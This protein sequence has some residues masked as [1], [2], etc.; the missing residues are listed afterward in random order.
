M[1]QRR[2]EIRSRKYL[3]GSRGQPCTLQITGVCTGDVE[4]T[5]AAH[6]R[7]ETFGKSQKAD[8]ISIADA[9]YACHRVFDGH[10]HTPL[11]S[12][13]WLFYALRGLQ[14][15]FRNRVER[16]LVIVPLDA[17]RLSSERPVPARKPAA[18]RVRIPSNPDRK[19]QSQNNLRKS[20]RL[21]TP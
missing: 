6:I 3:N 9:C 4:T 13:E 10:G 7:D 19:I 14:R 18:Q 5:V 16:G 11:T 2:T 20:E 8:D 12:E 17:E 21:V 1:T 15:T